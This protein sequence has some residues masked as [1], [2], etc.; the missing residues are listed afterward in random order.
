MIK[1]K[2]TKIIFYELQMISNVLYFALAT[3]HNKS[4]ISLLQHC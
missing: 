3:C 2:V 4:N 1:L